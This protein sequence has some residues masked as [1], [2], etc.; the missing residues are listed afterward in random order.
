MSCEAKGTSY[1][2]CEFRVLSGSSVDQK[3]CTIQKHTRGVKHIVRVTPLK[4][5]HHRIK[6][7]G[8]INSDFSTAH[9]HFSGSTTLKN[10]VEWVQ[11]KNLSTV[12]ID[13]DSA[14]IV[15]AK[16]GSQDIE[17][18]IEEQSRW[19]TKRVF[20]QIDQGDLTIVVDLI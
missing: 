3:A 14:E 16:L 18:V 1:Y 13:F 15:F 8:R 7:T 10:R 12:P 11:T 6:V 19:T 4:Q 20:N 2:D 5:K 17:A 9:A